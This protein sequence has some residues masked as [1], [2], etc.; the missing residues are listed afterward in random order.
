MRCRILAVCAAHGWLPCAAEVS[1][2]RKG[3]SFQGLFLARHRAKTGPYL[4]GGFHQVAEA[5]RRHAFR[6]VRLAAD[7][8]AVARI[9]HLH[10]M[11]DMYIR[12]TEI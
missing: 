5:E 4:L 9:A 3:Y 7:C 11:R 2:G 6:A 10:R 12:K 8:R 1:T